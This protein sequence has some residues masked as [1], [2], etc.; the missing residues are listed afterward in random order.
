MG[1]RRDYDRRD[2]RSSSDE[3]GGYRGHERSYDRRSRSPKKEEHD[4]TKPGL[5][6]EAKALQ[7]K[8]DELNKSLASVSE[9]VEKEKLKKAEEER[10]KKEAEEEEQRLIREK[11]VREKKARKK[12]AK[13]QK[14]VECEATM[15]ERLA[16]RLATKTD[17]FFDRVQTELG[18]AIALTRKA[19]A[20]KKKIVVLSE[21]ESD[22]DQEYEGSVTESLSKQT[23]NLTITE[24]R[25]R[26]SEPSFDDSPPVL[27]PAK[28]PRSTKTK[29]GEG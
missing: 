12:L 25:K 7:Q 19:K 16:L 13:Q 21:S 28:T 26:G 1:D 11:E 15:E 27:T 22:S 18:P 17:D 10:W 3:R 24:K 6:E 9:F 5:T 8:I 2:R 20:K 29:A 14:E 4:V 23:R